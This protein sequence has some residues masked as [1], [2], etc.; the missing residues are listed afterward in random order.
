MNNNRIINAATEAIIE[1]TLRLSPY[2]LINFFEAHNVPMINNI[3]DLLY[4][5][6]EYSDY[7]VN[8]PL[9]SLINRQIHF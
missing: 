5:L 7:D 3:Y 9:D 6:F 4:V 1:L 8:I 2:D